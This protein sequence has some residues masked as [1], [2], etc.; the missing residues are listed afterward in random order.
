MSFRE[1]RRKRQLMPAEE[2]EKILTLSTS[3]ILSVIGDEGYPYGVPVSYLYRNGK[4]YFHCAKEGHKIDALR[5]NEK[6]CFTVVAQDLIVPAELTSY[7]RSVVVFGKARFIEEP[8]EKRAAIQA[9]AEKY[10]AA[11][12][13]KIQSEIDQLLDKMLMVE[14]TPEHITGKQAIELVNGK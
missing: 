5:A 2:A 8:Q 4:I 6:V 13:E 10:G 12:P 7:F 9:L 14:I 11:Y 1:M 3:G